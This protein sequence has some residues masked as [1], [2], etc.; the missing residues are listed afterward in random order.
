MTAVAAV[1][2]ASSRTGCARLQKFPPLPE[3]S[4]TAV[5]ASSMATI[6]NNKAT[7][8]RICSPMSAA[9]GARA[10]CQTMD[11]LRAMRRVRRNRL[12]LVLRWSCEVHRVDFTTVASWVAERARVS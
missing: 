11:K 10:D 6:W 5:K 2:A 7:A 12:S 4:K 3:I 8:L 9:N 1:S